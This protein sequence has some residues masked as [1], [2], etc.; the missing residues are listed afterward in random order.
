MK[1]AEQKIRTSAF[2]LNTDQVEKLF[3]RAEKEVQEGLLSASQFALAKHGEVVVRGAFG[4]ANDDSMLAVF[5]CTKAITSTAAWLLIESGEL[6]VMRPVC[7]LVPEFAENGKEK[8]TIEQLFT[9]TAGFPSA[10]MGPAEG[11]DPERRRSR[12]RR[13]RLNWPAGE[14]FEYH[15]SSSMYAIADIIERITGQGWR[16]FARSRILEPLGI[17]NDLQLGLSDAA[18]QR[19]LKVEYVGEALTEA[20]YHEVGMPVPPVT[21][22]TESAILSFNMPEVQ[23]AGM[24]GG[25]AYATASALA[26]FYQALL[27][28][29]GFSSKYPS[30]VPRIWQQQTVI[31]GLRIRDADLIDPLFGKLVNRTLGLVVAGDDTRNYRGFGHLNSPSAFGHGGAGGQVAWADPATGLSFVYVTNGHDRNTLRRGRREVSMS[32]AAARCG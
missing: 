13:W 14:K 16:D 10:P 12:F 27:R 17:A 31:D 8:V 32:N 18:R 3:E 22:V 30:S 5:S 25:G 15:P 19:A 23:S 28:D 26:R 9:H 11:S 6:D 21:E 4:G 2:G 20:D 1:T 7:E 24:P 29:G